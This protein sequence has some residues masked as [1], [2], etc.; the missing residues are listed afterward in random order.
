MK[1]VKLVA[2]D[3]DGTLLFPDKAMPDWAIPLV[4][5]LI[6]QDIMFAVSS[7]RLYH[8]LMKLFEEVVHDI[9]LIAENGALVMD[10]G[11][12]VYSSVITREDA[13]L[14]LEEVR[15]LPGTKTTICGLDAGYLFASEIED[16]ADALSSGYFA[17]PVVIDTIDDIPEGE[18]ILKFAIFD[19]AGDAVTTIRDGLAH[20]DHKF[21]VAVSGA[22][23]ADI[24]NVGVN[25]GV[26]MKALQAKYGITYEETMAFGD[27][28]NDM[29]M[30]SEAY[31][32]Y[33]MANGIPELKAVSNFEAP[34]NEESG[35]LK[36]V[37]ELLAGRV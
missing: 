4:K 31:Y 29:E 1:N 10:K 19:E 8:N 27:Q 14:L 24:M 6:D 3:M 5:R 35:V 25:K 13:R 20:V 9:V 15:K 33:A 16:L 23:W 37:E 12:I 22:E 2:V 7:G 28:L 30:M 26:A 17:N 32:S 21:Q 36:V 18:Q 34:S 11:E